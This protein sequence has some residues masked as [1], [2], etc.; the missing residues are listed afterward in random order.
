MKCLMC[1]KELKEGVVCK[2]CQPKVTENFCYEVAGCDVKDPGNELWSELISDLTQKGGR[3][4]DFK[5]YAIELANIIES[6]RSIFVKINCANKYFPRTT[7]VDGQSEWFLM[8]KADECINNSK[9]KKEEKNLVNA[10]VLYVHIK[11]YEWEKV[12]ALI[13]KISLDDT[14]LEPYYVLWEYYKRIRNY[15]KA[16]EILKKA[17]E[18]FDENLEKTEEL[19]KET[20]ERMSGVKKH[21]APPNTR[22]KDEFFAYLD[23]LGIEHETMNNSKKLKTSQKDLKPF[24]IYKNT[25][26]PKDYVAFWITSEFHFKTDIPVELSAVKVV[27]GDVKEYFHQFFKPLETPKAY[28]NVKKEDCE[29]AQ[30]IR[31]VF[32]DFIKFS[33]GQVLVS[34][35]FSEQKSS[36]G[37]LVRYSLM[38]ELPNTVLDV[39]QLFED[40]SDDF[41]IYTRESLLAKYK[42]KE[43]KNGEEKAMATVKLIE[44]LR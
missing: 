32:P 29:N 25:D 44:K 43:G 39:I 2:T 1:G 28:K 12:D 3:P 42:V 36:L 26:V 30:P 21:W 13:E 40:I 31:N 6:D 19:L 33:A 8:K 11:N 16:L 38:N 37:R 23:K 24:N 5:R 27:N 17:K 14:Y 4:S 7:G 9:L 20:E 22:M 18:K 34:L 41:E 35:G 15:D 10:L